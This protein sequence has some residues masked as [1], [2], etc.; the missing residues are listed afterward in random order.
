MKKDQTT[1]STQSTNAQL[2]DLLDEAKNVGREIDET[3]NQA[4]A[5]LDD[6][7]SKVSES[8]IAVEK[9]Y[10]DLDQIEKEAGDEMDKLILQQAEAL[11]EE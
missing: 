7:D 10:S 4:G 8:V 3:N 5:A 2:N 6:I 1:Q 11:A 9:I